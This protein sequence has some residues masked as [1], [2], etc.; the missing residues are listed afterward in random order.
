MN[1]PWNRAKSQLRRSAQM[2][3]IDDR[4]LEALIVP[5]NI[6]EKRLPLVF[7]NGV[8]KYFTAYR[9]Q[10][11]NI[12]GPYKGGIR[13][14]QDVNLDE[15]KALAFWMTMKT[16]LLNVPFGGGK[17]GIKVDPK[18]LTK[19][20]LKSLTA[21]FAKSI[22][23]AIGPHKDI[24]APDVNTNPE[25][26]SWF[27]Q[28]YGE[29]SG[30]HEAAV[31][32]GKKLEHGGSKGRPEA[33]GLGG[34]FVLLRILKKLGIKPKGL[35]IAVQGFGN[36]GYHAAYYLHKA[37]CRIVA[38]SDSQYGIYSENGLDPEVVYASKKNNGDL[39]S[40]LKKREIKKIKREELLFL[41]VDVLIPAALENVITLENAESI[42]AG[43]V[44][45]LANGPTNMEA[46]EL[47]RKKGKLVIP[48]ILANAGGVVVS[49]FE[50]Y[51]NIHD[52]KWERETVFAKLKKKMH[53]AAD[54]VYDLH[55]KKLLAMRDA[56]YVI[57]LQRIHKQ[58]TRKN[59]LRKALKKSK[60]TKQTA[61]N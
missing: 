43:I 50:W 27:A 12:M 6:I 17:G 61:V 18:R 10:H 44:L 21:L 58:W 51:Q 52:K 31:V 48:D 55:K 2:L 1:N 59:L 42:K 3:K 16:A 8:Q 57:S 37:G 5:N 19:T 38:V 41:D 13:Y 47:L 32:T 35:K 40:G 53:E 14:H 34:V 29:H 15:I 45:E 30:K 4:L 9:V 7:E 11:N 49:Y 46:D 39:M 23:S 60:A 20:E 56:S 28:A 22:A 33:T 26:M 25:I 36:A 54:E 24:P